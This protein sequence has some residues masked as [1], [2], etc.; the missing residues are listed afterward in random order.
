MIDQEFLQEVEQG[1]SKKEKSLPSR[2]FYDAKGDELF[3]KIMNT[4]EYYLTRA[5]HEVLR[6]QTKSILS[7]TGLLKSSFRLV[8]LGAGDGTKT[9]E[10]LKEL[11]SKA[12]FTYMPIDISSNALQNLEGRIH[13]ELP[14]VSVEP[15]Q[16]EYFSVLEDLHRI[17]EPMFILFLG[18]NLGNMLD[19]RAHTFIEHIDQVMSIG[20]A[21]LLGLDLKKDEKIILPAYND[22]SGH[23]KDF[24]LNLLHRIN[25]EFGANFNVDA[26]GHAPRYDSDQGVA[27][28]YIQSLKDQDVRID[29]LD[30]IFHFEAGELI[31]TEISRKYDEDILNNIL[32]GTGLSI[33]RVFTDSKNY[34]ADYLLKKK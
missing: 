11:N 10:L 34:F 30:K 13:K 32:A 12:D 20:D 14:N 18:S 5:E 22:S 23:T 25:S 29:A 9:L 24:N 16:G 15:K 1:L 4:P 27:F 2:Y 28:S 19:D 3:V 6:E 26:F 33:N 21:L 8:E 7:A 17:D 31:H